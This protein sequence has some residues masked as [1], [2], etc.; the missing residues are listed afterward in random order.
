MW[1]RVAREARLV[2]NLRRR[3]EAVIE[4]ARAN[5]GNTG[6]EGFFTGVLDEVRIYDRALS[7]EEAA[8]LTGMR[9]P[10]HELF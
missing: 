9:A 7:A 1:G 3:I 6:R 5:S 8:W 10:R 4:I 2:R